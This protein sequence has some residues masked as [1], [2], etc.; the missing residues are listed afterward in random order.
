[1]TCSTA[2]RSP[3]CPSRPR[4]TVWWLPGPCTTSSAARPGRPDSAG[5]PCFGM[6]T[7]RSRNPP[8][9]H[10]TTRRSRWWVPDSRMTPGCAPSRARRWPASLRGLGTT[11]A[12]A[13][14]RLTCA[15]WPADGSTPTSSGAS[16]RVTTRPAH[17]WRRRPERS[18]WCPPTTP[19]PRSRR[20][21]ASPTGSARPFPSPRARSAAD[22]ARGLEFGGDRLTAHLELVE[23]AD[24]RGGLGQS[25][26]DGAQHQ[27]DGRV[28]PPVGDELHTGGGQGQRACRGLALL[29]VPDL[30]V[31]L[32][33][34]GVDRVVARGVFSGGLE[35]ALGELRGHGSGL[36]AL[37]VGVED[38]DAGVFEERRLDR[39]ERGG[40]LFLETRALAARGRWTGDGLGG[41]VVAAQGERPDQTAQDQRG[42]DEQHVR[43]P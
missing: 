9:R 18:S 27:I 37:A 13:P 20:R 15:W 3:P 30:A 10:V 33:V 23:R 34:L 6:R 1:S 12:Q 43:R 4:S 2:S 7:G 29:A 41:G 25:R 24:R 40:G 19:C 38:P 35:T 36:P 14:L 39:I 17:W 28:L 22:V 16:R 26:E 42:H 5:A 31:A 8:F 21:P 32:Q 11:A